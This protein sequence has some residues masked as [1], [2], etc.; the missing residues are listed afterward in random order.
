MLHNFSYYVNPVPGHAEPPNP[1]SYIS[2]LY[3]RFAGARVVA[4]E[5]DGPRYSVATDVPEIGPIRNAPEI[6]SVA[7]RSPDGALH[8]CLLNR[9]VDRD[10]NVVVRIPGLAEEPYKAEIRRFESRNP[11]E[12]LTWQSDHDVFEQR[13]EQVLADPRAIPLQLQRLSLT[14]MRLSR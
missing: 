2:E 5:Y 13:T 9:G 4:V 7:L 6:D 11:S 14:Y 12:R 10:Y 1:R 3:R 8:L